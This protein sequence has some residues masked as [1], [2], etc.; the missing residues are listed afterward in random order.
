VSAVAERRRGVGRSRWILFFGLAIV[1]LA[2]DQLTKSLVVGALTVGQRVQVLGDLLT[3][4][5]SRNSGAL[6]GLLPQSATAFAGVSVVVLIAI[7]WFESRQGRSTVTTI[8]LGLLLGG[9][10]GNLLDR[11][12]YG[13]VVD[14][15]DMGIGT[16]RWYT[17]NVADAAISVAI[18]AFILLAVWPRLAEVG[19]GD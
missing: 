3:I 13:S 7:V 9:A 1:V 8:A 4:I 16:I 5:H 14:F 2:L 6:F 18:V 19:T 10:I 11:V 15:V 12:R 17:F